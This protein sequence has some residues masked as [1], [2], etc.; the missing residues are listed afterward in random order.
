MPTRYLRAEELAR[1]ADVAK[2]T[3]LAAI[4]R[5]EIR[6]SRTLGRGTRISLESA[7]EYLSKRGRDV[8]EELREARVSSVAVLTENRQLFDRVREAC[9][10]TWI[11]AG[12][13]TA[14]STLVWIGTHTP[15][16]VVVDLDM[17]LLNPFEVIRC[18][19]TRPD[20]RPPRIIATGCNATTVAAARALG[21]SEAVGADD[22]SALQ[23]A[24]RRG[25]RESMI[26]ALRP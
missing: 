16:T 19:R 1:H 11:V 15:A 3:V 9:E 23:H 6:S 13:R 2:S 10:S 26:N 25:E 12:D 7:R 4:R 18:L 17:A 24:L 14:Y 22:G 5:G 8:P 20:M 21:A